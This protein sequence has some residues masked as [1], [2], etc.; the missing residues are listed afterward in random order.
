ML[1]LQSL[2]KYFVQGLA[3]AVASYLV[4]RNQIKTEEILVIALTAAAVYSVLDT[5]APALGV[6]ARLGT[7][8]SLGM[9]L[10]PEGY[11]N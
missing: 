1:D 7:G 8:V 6:G 11:E 9:K 10:V 4:M 3:V 2:V 5:Y